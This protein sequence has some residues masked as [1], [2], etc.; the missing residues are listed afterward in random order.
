MQTNKHTPSYLLHVAA[1]FGVGRFVDLVPVDWN[2]DLLVQLEDYE[3]VI[4]VSGEHTH[5]RQVN[6]GEDDEADK[7]A[8][9]WSKDY[10]GQPV[11]VI[12]GHSSTN[13]HVVNR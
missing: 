4:D 3:G 7:L 9:P 10:L 1:Q 2:L 5:T 6:E 12:L 11:V 13:R 8:S